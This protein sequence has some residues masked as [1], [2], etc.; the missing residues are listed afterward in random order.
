MNVRWSSYLCDGGEL[1]SGMRCIVMSNMRC[2][3]MC[4]MKAGYTIHYTVLYTI[5][6]VKMIGH[7]NMNLNV[8]NGI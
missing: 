6:L 1:R 5:H 7:H 2:N 4:N 8:Y 3:M